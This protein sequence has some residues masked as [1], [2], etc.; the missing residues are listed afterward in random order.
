MPVSDL[1]VTTPR[2][3]RDGQRAVVRAGRSHASL[4]VGAAIV[5]TV[6]AGMGAAV[7]LSMY[8]HPDAFSGRGSTVSAANQAAEAV[9][10]GSVEQVAAEV[11]PSVVELQIASDSGVQVGSGI[12]L[13]SDGLI[14]TNSHLAT[15]PRDGQTRV[16]VADGRTAPFSF[17]GADPVDDI[18]VVRAQVLS[19]L[20]PIAMGSSADLQVGQKVVAVGSPLGLNGTVTLGIISALNRPLASAPDPPATG[21]GV[22]QTDA[23]LNP[24]SFGG[25]L[26]DMTGRLIGMTVAVAGPDSITGQTGSTGLG[27]AIPVDKTKPIADRLIAAASAPAPPTGLSVGINTD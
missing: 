18:A 19:D 10:G 4:F 22:I 23:A 9:K 3:R 26:V 2:H 15:A 6:S 25:A 13:T 17:V 5:A 14:L 8:P 24:G 12:V 11:L 16:V 20:T 1:G 27:F 7:A 21:P